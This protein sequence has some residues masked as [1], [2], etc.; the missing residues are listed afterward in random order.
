MSEER[1]RILQM[2]A[3]GKVTPE[4]GAR[5]IEALGRTEQ[6]A[7]KGETL[8]Q[9]SGRFLVIRFFESEDKHGTVRVPLELL[10]VATRFVPADAEV[11]VGGAKIKPSAI[12]AAVRE[13]LGY[14]D[15]ADIKDG[16]EW[17][18]ISIEGPGQ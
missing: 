1:M 6:A 18:K 7:E 13:G 14:G 2:V 4:E 17:V 9:L 8:P 3:E 12:L 16:E 10:D 11:E 15:I 5:L